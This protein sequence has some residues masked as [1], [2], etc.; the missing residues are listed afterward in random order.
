MNE[1]NPHYYK[2]TNRQ[3]ILSI[4]LLAF[5]LRLI[6][7]MNYGIEFSLNSDDIGYKKS[8][9]NLIETGK[10]TYHDPTE[11]TVHIMPGMSILLGIVYLIFGYGN[12]GIF[13]AK[14]LMIC[15][16]VSSVLGTYVVADKI[17]G[18]KMIANISAL[19]L[20]VYIP[21]LVTDNLLLS[22]SPYTAGM[23]FLIYFS[24][25]LV[26][27]KRL[28]YLIFLTVFYLFCLFLRPTVALYPLIFAIYLIY[29]RYPIKLLI[30]HG[31]VAA[32]LIVLCLAPWWIRNYMV[33]DKF[34][35]LS[36]STGNPMLLGSFQGVGYPN[37]LTLDETVNEIEASNSITTWFERFQLQKMVA[38]ERI[39]EWFNNNPKEFLYSYLVLKPKIMWSYA[40]YWIP[41]FD[42]S[43]T[44]IHSVHNLL[45]LLFLVGLVIHVTTDKNKRGESIFIVLI[46][47]YFT[48]TYSSFFAFNRYNQ[49]LMP[50]IIIYSSVAIFYIFKLFARLR[51]FR[52]KKV[53]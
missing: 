25:L 14:L 5:I 27:R 18:N 45:L 49:T 16:G 1:I 17:T 6:V 30:K 13:L 37:E 39:S 28:R 34:I 41:I 24:L 10:L 32:I 22:E 8:A 53:K 44:T 48:Y 33:F 38:K 9:I 43:A 20:A 42:I 26:E 15:C 51:S 31:S 19:L 35:P 21:Q 46:L 2:I 47:L 7:L 11:P 40:F 29:K 4:L 52:M 36:E 50:L 12:V 23:L 3:I